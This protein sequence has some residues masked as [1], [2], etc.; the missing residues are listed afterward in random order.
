MGD[1]VEASVQFR[2][3]S[4]VNDDTVDTETDALSKLHNW[5]DDIVGGYLVIICK[6]VSLYL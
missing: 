2:N 3:K 5:E 6:F 4:D 1:A